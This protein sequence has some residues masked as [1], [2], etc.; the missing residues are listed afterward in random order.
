VRPLRLGFMRLKC[1]CSRSP[2]IRSPVACLGL[3]PSGTLM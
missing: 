1:H 3:C 2:T